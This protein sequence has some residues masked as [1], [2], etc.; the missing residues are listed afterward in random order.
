[1]FKVDVYFNTDLDETVEYHFSDYFF[2]REPK[3]MH[4][5]IRHT[6]TFFLFSCEQ[7][8]AE[9]KLQGCPLLEHQR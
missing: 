2:P 7:Q 1:M 3:C 4:S 6:Y 9:T 8:T 5:K